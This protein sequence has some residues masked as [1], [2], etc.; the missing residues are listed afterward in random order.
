MVIFQTLQIQEYKEKSSQRKSL[1]NSV[2]INDN[3]CFL[4]KRPLQRPVLNITVEGRSSTDPSISHRLRKGSRT[5]FY[6]YL[7]LL[8]EFQKIINILSFSETKILNEGLPS[9]FAGW[10]VCSFSWRK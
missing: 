10:F 3:D 9:L 6:L 7:F 8:F 1:G 2:I 5:A 4:N